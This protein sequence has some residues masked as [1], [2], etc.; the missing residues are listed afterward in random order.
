MNK[1]TYSDIFWG[2]FFLIGAGLLMASKLGWLGITMGWWGWLFTIVLAAALVQSIAN[3]SIGGVVWSLAFL[4]IIWNRALG[5]ATLVPWTVLGVALLVHIGLSLVLH[6]LLKHHH[7]HLIII[8]NGQNL[9]LTHQQDQPKEAVSR[10]QTVVITT[11]LGS[12]TRYVQSPDFRLADI[13]I[14]LGDAKVYFD[15]ATILA[16]HAEIAVTGSLG[17]LDL[18]I[19]ANWHL[20]SELESFLG[21][22]KV[23]GT[24]SD[25][26]GPTVYLTGGFKLGDIKVHYI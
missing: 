9:T 26:V 6:P 10:D 13:T 7:S 24:P 5:I 21:D 12:V 14:G 11:K 19:P 8:K 16:D 4:A 20:Q 17:D 25:A 22:V 18:Y 15:K 1:K 2:M 23:V 3:L